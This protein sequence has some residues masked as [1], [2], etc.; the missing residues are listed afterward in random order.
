MIADSYGPDSPDPKNPFAAPVGVAADVAD[1]RLPGF[2]SLLTVWF[3]PRL[4]I[5]RIV[6]TQPGHLVIPLASCEGI[7]GMLDATW[8]NITLPVVLT[9]TL[10]AGPIVG[11]LGLWLYAWLVRIAGTWIGGAASS[12]HLRAALAWGSVPALAKIPLSLVALALMQ[13]AGFDP[14]LPITDPPEGLSFALAAIEVVAAVLLLWSA[15]LRCNTVAEVQGFQSAWQGF[16]NLLLAGLLV[17]A[18]VLAVMVPLFIAWFVFA[19][20]AS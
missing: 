13:S 3:H 12:E 8:T 1:G 19:L 9:I 7:R 15:V 17:A 4:T 18:A 11:I 5:R 14:S 16:A 10:L 6:D 2:R 20:R